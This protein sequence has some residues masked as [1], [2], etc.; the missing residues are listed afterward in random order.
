M[1][2]GGHR[3]LRLRSWFALWLAV[4]LAI[5]PFT[6]L[7]PHGHLTAP[8]FAEASV[9]TDDQGDQPAARLLPVQPTPPGFVSRLSL[10]EAALGPPSLKPVPLR[11]VA[12][13]PAPARHADA[14]S[15]GEPRT[16]LERSSVGT[17]RTPTGPPA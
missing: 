2:V 3:A 12:Q 8:A 10:V 16:V 1:L 4:L 11:P 9:A 13:Q 14:A 5:G 7:V 17:A 6:R 15:G